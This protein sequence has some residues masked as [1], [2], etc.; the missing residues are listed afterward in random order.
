MH[1]HADAVGFLTVAAYLLI[2]MFLFRAVAARFSDTAAGKGL[3]VI[4][5]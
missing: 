2:A 1:V 5:G 3:G 4:V